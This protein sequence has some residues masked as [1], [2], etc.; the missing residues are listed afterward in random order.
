MDGIKLTL[1]IID[2][3]F[4][5]LLLIQV[6]YIF[7]FACHSFRKK[8][9][10]YPK[11][12]SKFK[13]VVLIPAY[14]DDSVIEKTVDSILNQTVDKNFYE[15]VVIS[16]HMCEETNK[17]LFLKPIILF[18]PQFERSS[19]SNALKYA[20]NNLNSDYSEK[21]RYDIAVI[22]DSD[23]IVD[24]NFLQ[25][26]WDAFDNGMESIQAH[27]VAKNRSAGIS[28]LDA[29]SEE[30][31]NS[32][33]RK[34]P[35]KVGLSA[36]LIGSGMAFK[37][38]WFSKNVFN[39]DS[40]GEDKEFERLLLM[41]GIFTDYLEN[42]FVYDEKIS[43]SAS[44]YAQRR[45]WM[46]AQAEILKVAIKDLPHAIKIGNW[47][48][49]S[50]IFQWMLLPRVILVGVLGCLSAVLTILAPAYSIKWW[51][52]FLILL[53]ALAF[54]LPDYIVDKR[55]KKAIKCAPWLAV[56]MF[57]NLFRMKNANKTFIHTEHTVK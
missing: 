45:R 53:F 21:E 55:F 17:M 30:I 51:A 9:R 28:V 15:V 3:V 54:A 48:Y 2:L 26:I 27:R 23:N 33:F 56:L 1:E 44:F 41:E 47:D 22:L 42:T 31:N 36:A 5:T 18:T 34:A 25:D 35:V 8:C 57:C 38:K 19:K 11:T 52:L 39:T 50:R 40:A 4:F 32:L 29:A 43:K 14:G 37:Y 10:K 12:E 6:A 13:T 7:Y 20:I 24:Q 46:A 16:D 49:C